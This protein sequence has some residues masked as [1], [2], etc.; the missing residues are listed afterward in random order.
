LGVDTEIRVPD[1]GDFKD[2]EVIEVL[3]SAGDTLEPGASLITIESE[4]ASME[5]PCPFGGL[6][7]KV[8]VA[9]GDRVSEGDLL[10]IMDVSPEA[11]EEPRP[12]SEAQPQPEAVSPES[13]A[14]AP[15]VQPEPEVASP[16][17]APP[18]P[19]VRRSPSATGRGGHGSPSVRRLARE[20]GVDLALVRGSGRKGR[21][22]K[23]DVQAFV[24]GALGGGAPI[25]IPDTVVQFEP[26][27]Q[28]DFA[29]FGEVAV[30]PLS[31][32]RRLSAASL[33]R[34][35]VTVPHVT[36]HD[37]ADITDLE[38][39][40]KQNRDDAERRGVSL[41]ILPFLMKA[42]VKAIK[43]YPQFG[44]SL[45]GSGE[46][47]IIK[48]YYHLGIAVDTPNGLVVP[49][50]RDVDRK[51][52]IELAEDLAHTSKRARSRKLRP[53]DL[54]GACFTISSLGSIGGTAFTPIVNAPE[55]AI[56][57]VSRAAWKPVWV[58]GEFV[59]RLMLP[60]SLSYDHRVIDGAAAVRFTTRLC[61]LLAD[62]RNLVL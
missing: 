7:K 45:D 14:P 11:A 54:Q 59:A 10:L 35:W 41:T 37:E 1:I 34:S 17:S 29:S 48:K 4:K 40:R 15:T 36:Q 56:L 47:L 6:V 27:P 44:A 58:D 49:V 8:C 50:I 24:K 28:I 39:F 2:V 9:V 25:R 55:V 52:A 33:H 61:E 46:N 62:V 12:P 20:L 43:E 16:R 51:S 19:V 30:L 31:K 32:I 22:L 13:A 21:I 42:V 60:L 18:S 38:A 3:V 23:T 26:P 53:P 57:G 5:I